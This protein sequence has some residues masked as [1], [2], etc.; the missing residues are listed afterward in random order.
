MKKKKACEVV[1]GVGKREVI[2]CLEDM[3]THSS[4]GGSGALW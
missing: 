2:L 1:L 4:L 3:G